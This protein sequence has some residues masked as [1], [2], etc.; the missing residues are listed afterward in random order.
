[1]VIE[2]ENLNKA[3]EN[4][5]FYNYED[6]DLLSITNLKIDYVF[7]YE[8]LLNLP[9]LNEIKFISL[10]ITEDLL[11]VLNHLKKLKSIYFVNC[12]ISYLGILDNNF[13]KIYFERC[14]I[15]DYLVINRFTKLKSLSFVDMGE[16]DLDII[17]IIRNIIDLNFMNTKIV[18]EDKLII[19]DKIENLCLDGADVHNID[20][21]VENESLKTLIID[22]NIYNNN[23]KVIHYLIERG[24]SVSNKYGEE[25]GDWYD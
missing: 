4:K 6:K 10:E 21:L 18:N 12:D 15:K 20:T 22:D 14:I 9:N 25:V 24:I 5:L 19:L 1:M 2:N 8:E 13:E 3:I 11:R 7:N 23:K 17:P 16:I